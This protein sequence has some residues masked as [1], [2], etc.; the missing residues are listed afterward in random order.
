VTVV[1]SQRAET[2][3]PRGPESSELGPADG[4][5][6]SFFATRRG[7]PTPCPSRGTRAPRQRLQAPGV[8]QR[9]PIALIRGFAARTATQ[10]RHNS[11]RPTQRWFALGCVPGRGGLPGR[12][13]ALCWAASIARD[14]MGPQPT[15]R[16]P[17]ASG[18]SPSS[19]IADRPTCDCSLPHRCSAKHGRDQQEPY[20]RVQVRTR[21]EALHHP[22]TRAWNSWGCT[23]AEPA[24]GHRQRAAGQHFGR[25]TAVQS[26][27]SQEPTQAFT[28]TSAGR[29]AP[30]SQWGAAQQ[31]GRPR[32][33]PGPA[34]SMC[35]PLWRVLGPGP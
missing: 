10:V 24:F 9:P 23:G 34:D 22:H 15:G 33:G 1:A 2:D 25:A 18:F 31:Q 26:A 3:A 8:V 28:A 29:V 14:V 16:A 35:K 13:A 12:P 7:C 20:T 19:V 27:S 17:A 11:Q 5:S 30:S 6:R 32:A 4:Q 21:A